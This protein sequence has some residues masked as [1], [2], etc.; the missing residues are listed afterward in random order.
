MSSECD[1][2]SPLLY[3]LPDSSLTASSIYLDDY[4][5][6][7]PHR[8]RLFTQ[9]ITSV[10]AEVWFANPNLDDQWI[11]ADLLTAR[12]VQAVALWPRDSGLHPWWVTSFKLRFS[13][14]DVS[15]DIITAQNGEERIFMGLTGYGDK[16]LVNFNVTDARFVQL[17]PITFVSYSALKW[18]VYACVTGLCIYSMYCI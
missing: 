4:D 5:I 17:L 16:V 8:S 6:R 13:L 7:G 12:S 9:F 18:E 14:D 2:P 1:N 15:Y 3:T 11:K 10:E